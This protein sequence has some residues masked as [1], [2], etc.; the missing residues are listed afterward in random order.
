MF[1][2]HRAEEGSRPLGQEKTKAKG[3]GRP[4]GTEAREKQRQKE[5]VLILK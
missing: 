5:A 4:Q 1:V 3:R 2:E